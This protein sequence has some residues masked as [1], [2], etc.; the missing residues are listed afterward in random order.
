MILLNRKFTKCKLISRDKQQ[1]SG[2]LGRG[3][4]MGEGEECLG[5]SVR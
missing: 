5:G 4:K 3:L 1:I 2:C